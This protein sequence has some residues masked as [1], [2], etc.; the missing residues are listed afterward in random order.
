[1]QKISQ[2]SVEFRI[3]I[4]GDWVLVDP[5]IANPQGLL[6]HYLHGNPYDDEEILAGGFF[7]HAN[8]K[9][10]T[11]HVE[12]FY[13]AQSWLDALDRACQCDA[14]IFVWAWEETNLH[15]W[16]KGS[17]LFME[18]DNAHRSAR[19]PRVCFEFDTFI[20]TFLPEA[21]KFTRL[22]ERL[23]PL[24]A[25]L[26]DPGSDTSG[27][28]FANRCLKECYSDLHAQRKFQKLNKTLRTRS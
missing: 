6:D 10:W 11:T 26:P 27:G 7:I 22:V 4:N 21:E 17:L 12:S 8:R 15:I 19:L 2:P 18:D 5:Y 1:M 14:K 13:N 24:I 23:G 20:N 16:C 3:P 25:A 9:P 28:A